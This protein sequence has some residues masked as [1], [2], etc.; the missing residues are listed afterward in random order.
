M[1]IID[2]DKKEIILDS[3]WTTRHSRDVPHVLISPETKVVDLPAATTYT[4]KRQEAI[5][6]TVLTVQEA[7]KKGF[8]S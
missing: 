3:S 6:K 2:T 7:A 5:P 4:I 8:D 1:L